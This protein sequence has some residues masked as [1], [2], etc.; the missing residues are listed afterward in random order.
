MIDANP[1]IWFIQVNGLAYD[2][3]ELPIEIQVEAYLKGV[4]PYVPDLGRD[5]TAAMTAPRS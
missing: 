1:M 3:R 5:A 4:I 2:V